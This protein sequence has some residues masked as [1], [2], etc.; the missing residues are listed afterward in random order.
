M[1]LHSSL[2][3]APRPILCVPLATVASPSVLSAAD[4]YSSVSTPFPPCDLLCQAVPAMPACTPAASAALASA[5]ATC[6]APHAAAAAAAQAR[7]AAPPAAAC[8][9]L[10]SR[11]LLHQLQRMLGWRIGTHTWPTMAAPMHWW[12]MCRMALRSYTY[13]QVHPGLL[14]DKCGCAH[15][16]CWP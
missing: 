3:L 2:I 1:V 10:A 9:C 14:A 7:R 5:S 8:W 12:H 15:V 11:R 4:A 16:S 6:W 13:T